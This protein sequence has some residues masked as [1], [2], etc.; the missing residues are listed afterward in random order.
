MFVVGEL[1]LAVILVVGASLL[2][3]TSLALRRVDPGFDP[4]N[5]ITMRMAVSGTRFETRAGISE[6]ARAGVERLQAIPGVVRASTTCCMPLETVWQLPFVIA[7][8]SGEGLTQAG[9]MTFHGFGG[10]TFVSPGYFDVFGIRI[11]RVATSRSRTMR[12]RRVSSSSTRRWRAD[13]GRPEIR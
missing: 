3:L 7:S 6:L 13:T 10:W 5:V 9:P 8:R 11:L 12:V 2:I 1:A 4:S